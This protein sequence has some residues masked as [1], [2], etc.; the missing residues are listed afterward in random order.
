[1]KVLKQWKRSYK[2]KYNIIK[3][4]ELDIMKRNLMSTRNKLC[5]GMKWSLTSTRQNVYIR[6]LTSTRQKLN[7]CNQKPIKNIHTCSKSLLMEKKDLSSTT[8]VANTVIWWII[9]ILDMMICIFGI[10]GLNMCLTQ[11]NPKSGYQNK[12]N[13]IILKAVEA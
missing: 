5:I 12:S 7:T 1:M 13:S 4:K 9:I 8:T 11:S 6:R 10:L 2:N 3:S